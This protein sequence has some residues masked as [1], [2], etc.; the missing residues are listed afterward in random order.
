MVVIRRTYT[1]KK[2]RSL[3]NNYHEIKERRY[4]KADYNAVVEIADLERAIKEA[5]LTNRQRE[6][7]RLVYFE[8][9]TQKEAAQIMNVSRPAVSQFISAVITKIARV[10]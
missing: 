8:R 5:D 10:I 9:L 2:V 1:R 4:N 3:L 6:A 7:L